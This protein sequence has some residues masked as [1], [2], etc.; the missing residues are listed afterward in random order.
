MIQLMRKVQKTK[1]EA[2]RGA[3]KKQHTRRNRWQSFSISDN[4][5][6]K[7]RT[8]IAAL[9]DEETSKEQLSFHL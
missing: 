3:N 7:E 6:T 4:E 1:R 8:I 9:S 5:N 2:K